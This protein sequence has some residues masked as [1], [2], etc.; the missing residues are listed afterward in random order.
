VNRSTPLAT[1]KRVSRLEKVLMKKPFVLAGQAYPT[2]AAVKER[3]RELLHR[4][5]AQ[6][7][8]PEEH[9]FLLDLLAHHSESEQK[10]GCGVAR[11]CVQSD[12]FGGSC[13]WLERFDG[14]RTDWSFN[15]CLTPPTHTKEVLSAFRY[16]ITDQVIRF[17]DAIFVGQN[18]VLCAIT[19]VLITSENSHVDHKPPAHFLALVEQFLSVECLS[20]DVIRVKPA[21]DGSTITEFEDS[22]LGTR[23]K[24]FHEKHAVLQIVSAFANL[25]QGTGRK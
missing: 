10:I 17:R 13:F 6:T 22:A 7:F 24:I 15:S 9:R 23:W 21:V 14:T 5:P 11:F 1:Q 4:S 2:K 18:G 16:L 20:Y 12:A 25:S 19:G 3:C 8:S